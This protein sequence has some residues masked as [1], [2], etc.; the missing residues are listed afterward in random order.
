MQV[1]TDIAD[2]RAF[3]QTHQGKTLALIPTM[4]ALHDGHLTLLTKAQS[5]ADVVM[6]SIFVNPLQFGPNEDF[7]RYPRPLEADL[8]KCQQMGIDAVFC[9]TAEALYPNGQSHLTQVLPPDGLAD[10]LCGKS[11]PGH[12]VGVATIVL[13]LLNIVQPDIA[14]FGEKDAQQLKI[15]SQMVSD[16]N[17]PISIVP[18]TTARQTS[19]LALSSRNDYLTND[20]EKQA[21]LVPWQVLSRIKTLALTAL[22]TQNT[23]DFR[24]I[25]HNVFE[26]TLASL[27]L[28]PD[29]VELDYLEAVNRFTF[30]PVKQ[31]NRFS[32]VLI[33]CKIGK[34]RLIDNIDIDSTVSD[35]I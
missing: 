13:K 7:E 24:V 10:Q 3:R 21:A 19:G 28:S 9:P 16:L 8:A 20:L 34:T 23:V 5:H 12:F 29:V 27:N 17:L 18:A 33:A 14:I 6:V 2:C 31:L 35:I 22:D 1:I 11:R 26:N 15:V 30:E 4:G 25:S 32:K